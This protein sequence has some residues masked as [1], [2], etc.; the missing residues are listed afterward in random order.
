MLYK[1]IILYDAAIQQCDTF[2][3][4]HLYKTHVLNFYFLKLNI[5]TFMICVIEPLRFLAVYNE[6]HFHVH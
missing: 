5:E 1:I 4:Q 6:Q 2:L 3:I